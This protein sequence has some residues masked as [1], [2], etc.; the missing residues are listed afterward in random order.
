MP[1]ASI[2]GM[3]RE[4]KTE[5]V[6]F[7]GAIMS[8]RLGAQF[9]IPSLTKPNDRLARIMSE[10]PERVKME[11]RV[12]PSLCPCFVLRML[13]LLLPCVT[14]LKTQKT[15]IRT[16]KVRIPGTIKHALQVSILHRKPL[17]AHAPRWPTISVKDAII[18]AFFCLCGSKYNA[19]I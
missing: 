6:P 14:P 17:R 2:T 3:I 15:A 16:G 5:S 8:R 4:S 9:M 18:L 11:K 1:N 12:G 10:K 19:I 13:L 7:P